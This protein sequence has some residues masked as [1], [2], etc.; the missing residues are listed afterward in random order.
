MEIQM[1]FFVI[2]RNFFRFF[3]IF[4]DVFV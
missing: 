3:F 2:F 1:R 4:F